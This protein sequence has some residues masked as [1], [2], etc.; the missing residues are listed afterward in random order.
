VN[1]LA[2]AL[3]TKCPVQT[4]RARQGRLFF[5]SL[6]Q[7]KLCHFRSENVTVDRSIRAMKSLKNRQILPKPG[8]MA[9]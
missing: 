5:G 4:T 6:Q 3:R 9:K 2:S 1:C 7:H 8:M